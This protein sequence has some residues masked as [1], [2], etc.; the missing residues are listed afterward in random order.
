MIG[1]VIPAHNEERVIERCLTSVMQSA[2]HDALNGRSVGIVVVLD[3]CSDGTRAIVAELGIAHIEV[4][5]RSV[6]AARAAGAAHM[7][8]KGATWLAFTDAD[9]HVAP[10]WL[11]RQ[12]GLNADA[13]CGTVSVYD[14]HLY[15]DVVRHRYEADY[16]DADGHRHIHGA[17]L[18]VCA[19]AYAKA[20]GFLP[21]T[22]DEDVALIASLLAR[23]ADVAFS[24][25]PR[26]S[27]SA[28]I[29]N[30]VKGGFGGLIARLCAEPLLLTDASASDISALGSP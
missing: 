17:N 7:L 4:S 25:A 1:V 15:P 16:R 30:R 18:G 27:T 22:Q 26:V 29:V 10:D 28:R 11:A 5:A 13:V 14:W 23:G 24:A 20:G 3:D 21:L 8:A 2:R 19:R 6:G 12:V 9:S